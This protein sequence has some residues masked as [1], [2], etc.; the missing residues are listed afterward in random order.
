MLSLLAEAA[1]QEPVRDPSSR[2]HYEPGHFT[3]S[4]FVISPDRAQM[5]LIRHRKLGLW[6]QPGG[7]FEDGDQSLLAAAERE[8]RE[9]TGLPRLR[10][11]S[12]LF[13]LDIHVIPGWADQPAHLHLDLRVLFQAE[14]WET[15]IGDDVM[16]VRWFPLEKLAEK[17]GDGARPVLAGGLSTDAGVA[18]V[19]RRVLDEAP[20]VR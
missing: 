18:E 16:D 3:A 8:A 12:P 20:G 17:V 2:N 15:V 6:L 1:G 11:E 4:A 13:D 10:V 14:S 5:L 9:E 19:A 7:H